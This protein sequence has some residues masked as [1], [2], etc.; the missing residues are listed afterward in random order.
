MQFEFWKPPICSGAKNQRSY[1]SC[2]FRIYLPNQNTFWNL[3]LLLLFFWNLNIFPLNLK[4]MKLWDQTK[5]RF[6][7][8]LWIRSQ[9]ESLNPISRCPN[10][11][12]LA[13]LKVSFFLMVCLIHRKELKNFI[14]NFK[15]LTIL[16]YERTTHSHTDIRQIYLQ[17]KKRE[18]K[19]NIYIFHTHSFFYK[20]HVEVGLFLIF[21]KIKVQNFLICS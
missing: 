17:T 18:T 14:L 16:S 2:H 7:E 13:K 4:T 21:S 9:Y 8:L 19:K 15:N 5:S 1:F 11:N 12:F 10:R 20:N 3:D 6:P